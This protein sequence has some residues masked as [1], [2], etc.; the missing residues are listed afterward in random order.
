MSRAAGNL[1]ASAP[2]RGSRMVPSR[3]MPEGGS[4]SSFGP[5]VFSPG[6]IS[7]GASV[8][9]GGRTKSLKQAKGTGRKP[10]TPN[11]KSYNELVEVA[12]RTPGAEIRM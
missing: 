11:K 3:S 6:G 5:L 1:S 2:V 10:G 7:S 9:S 12:E 4:P 8:E